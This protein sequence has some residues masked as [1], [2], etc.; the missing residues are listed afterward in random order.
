MHKQ[1]YFFCGVGGS[2]MFPLAAYLAAQGHEVHGSDRAFDQGRL[3]EHR[4]RIEA[5]G[6]QL[7]PQDGTG[8][9]S[10]EQTLVTSSAVEAQIPDVAA[11]KAVG[12]P[13]KIR[14]EVLA[15]LTN[16]SKVS[17]GVAGTSGKSTTTAMVA[18][19]LCAAG[20]QP[21]VVNGAGMLN[22]LDAGKRPNGWHSG[23]GPFV[24]EVDES[25][26]SIARYDPTVGVVLNI[27]EDHKTME[28]LIALFTGYAQRS[29][30][31]VVG[32]DSEAAARLLPMIKGR[33]VTT[34]SLDGNADYRASNIEQVPGSIAAT[35]YGPDSLSAKLELPLIGRFNISNA[36]AAIAA[37]AAA[38]VRMQEACAAL[39]TFAGTARRLQKVGEARGISVIDD[40]AHNP[41]KITSSIGAMRA[42]YQRLH[43]LYQP[44]GYG[45]LVKFRSLYEE[46]FA[47]AL[48]PKDRLFVS[49]PAYFGGTVTKTDD[50]QVLAQTIGAQA[51]YLEDRSDFLSVIDTAESGDAIVIMGARD[52]TLTNLAQAAFSQLSAA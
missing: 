27:S 36:L 39:S 14:A 19:I 25:D 7:F 46:A 47:Q 4:A 1:R 43:L 2:G 21:G 29:E 52:D 41:D 40:F 50:A 28:E 30:Q 11:A 22:F 8:L 48:G 32:I 35:V 51:T 15:G 17:L 20:L 26:G 31:V 3:P 5:C 33:N 49:Q 44:H 45:P 37:S 10:A 24:C 34:F 13:H 38:G 18:H 42:Q 16:A 9:V 12:A 23:N 6:I